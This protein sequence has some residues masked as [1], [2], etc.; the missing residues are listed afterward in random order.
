MR[1]QFNFHEM[2]HVSL[3]LYF[4]EKYN[5]NKKEGKSYR[6]IS[7][8]HVSKESSNALLQ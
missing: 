7:L 3:Q 8:L 2:R 1:R 5:I 6:V 4:A